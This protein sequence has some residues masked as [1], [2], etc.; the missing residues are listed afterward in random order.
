MNEKAELIINY[1]NDVLNQINDSQVEELKSKKMKTYVTL[2]D[3][4]GETKKITEYFEYIIEFSLNN[5]TIK[6]S[7]LCQKIAEESINDIAK[8]YKEKTIQNFHFNQIRKIIKILFGHQNSSCCRN[9]NKIKITVEQQD[10]RVIF[11][12]IYRKIPK[13]YALDKNNLPK[14]SSIKSTNLN[15]ENQ[16]FFSIKVFI[17]YAKEDEEVAKQLKQKLEESKYIEAWTQEDC[18]H[19]GDLYEFAEEKINQC[20]YLIV[21]L[22]EN[23]IKEPRIS[24]EIGLADELYKTKRNARPRILGLAYGKQQLSEPYIIKDFETGEDKGEYDF[25]RYRNIT[26]EDNLVN[27]LL[28][29]LYFIENVNDDKQKKLF[30]Q[31]IPVYHTLF[32]IESERDPEDNI[33]ERIKKYQL[34]DSKWRWKDHY[35]VLTLLNQVIGMGYFSSQLDKKWCF[36][37]YFGILPDHRLEVNAKC[38]FKGIEKKLKTDNPG[39]KGIIFEIE[40]P[41]LSFLTKVNNLSQAEK[42]DLKNKINNSKYSTDRKEFITNLR[43]LR[44]MNWFLNSPNTYMLLKREPSESLGYPFYYKQPGMEEPL[45]DNVVEDLIPLVSLFNNNLKDEPNLFQDIIE[46]LY[47]DVFSSEIFPDLD[48]DEFKNHVQTIKDEITKGINDY[49]FLGKDI[50]LE[51]SQEQRIRMTQINKLT[52]YLGRIANQCGIFHEIKL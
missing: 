3:L 24:R 49:C 51:L 37:N 36:G 48:K 27:M 43:R 2:L 18:D 34:K 10:I 8:K 35:V 47:N 46:F 22:S 14:S 28:P 32:P 19:A 5:L 4:D 31:S 39:L 30:Q 9:N 20:D 15:Q 23:A 26:L 41:D 17:S 44:R 11:N 25:S 38:F 52:R 13:E 6:V 7:E 40:K 33:A 21:I 45:E 42:D 29:K 1:L 12:E 16:E 50:Q